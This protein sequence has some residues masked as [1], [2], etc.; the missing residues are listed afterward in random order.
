MATY[1]RR[2]AWRPCW[3]RAGPRCLRCR[4]RRRNRTGWREEAPARCRSGWRL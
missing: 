4:G 3:P 2:I 1:N